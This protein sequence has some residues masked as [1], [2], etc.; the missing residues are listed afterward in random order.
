MTK[1]PTRRSSMR[2]CNLRTSWIVLLCAVIVFTTA[3]PRPG[4]AADALSL[5]PIP[6]GCELDRTLFLTSPQ[7]QGPDVE[8]LQEHLT[9]SGYYKG[10]IDGIYGPV[11]AQAVERFQ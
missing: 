5:S 7:L 8:E 4:I 6:S 11:T 10:K 1:P 2:S 3:M 9:A